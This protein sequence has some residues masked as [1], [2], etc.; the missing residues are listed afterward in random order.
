MPVSGPT[1]H[2]Q[3]M[4]AYQE[5]QHELEA[6]R[7]H[8]AAAGVELNEL[9]NNR[10]EAMVDLAQHYLPELTQEAV[11]KTWGDVQQ[12]VWGVLMRKE[13]H[14]QRLTAAIADLS[15]KRD[16]AEQRLQSATL[17]LDAAT[18]AQ[19]EISN[20][21]SQELSA[22]KRFAEL[23]DRAAQAEAALQRAEANLAEIEIDANR[24]LPSYENSALF[25][26]LHKRGFLTPQ[27]EH[28]GITRS[29]DQW[30]GRYIGYREA[31]H[32]YEFLK[33]TPAHMKDVIAEDRAAL[34]T[35]LDELEKQRDIVAERHGLPQAIQ[36]TG[37]LTQQREEILIELDE[38]ETE[39]ERVQHELTEI[40]NT[41]GPYYHEAIKKF[42]DMI[43][44][45][46]PAALADRARETP[47]INDDR[48]VARLQGLVEA[49][50]EMG[51]QV[52]ERHAR[53]EQLM[54]H[55]QSVGTLISRFRAAGF[56]SSQ[57]QFGDAESVV[58]QLRA[59]RDGSG[60][61]EDVWQR[62]RRSHRWGPSAADQFV[63]VATHPMTQ[64][65][66]SAMAHA[67]AGALVAKATQAGGRRASSQP[68]WSG[69]R[70]PGGGRRGGG[71]H[72]RDSF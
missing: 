69:G 52:R 31:R 29:M 46:D 23:S 62:L 20:V 42:R 17:A 68:K 60:S 56:D 4:L 65:L 8:V 26:Y 19:G 33:T 35:V 45:A 10:G 24:K 11:R 38:I 51:D 43:A 3:L 36:K 63:R 28:R 40:E 54:S 64:V 15:S 41:R 53:I 5:A 7:G 1:I 66:I 61:Y 48:I 39:T 49:M 37:D 6:A 18:E 12:A 70:S 57:A 72:T 47:E 21:V 22:D 27:Y 25:M 32:G 59:V 58:E 9:S 71:F 30:L 34:N 14:A 2:Q 44:D 55:L 13:E 16:A 50:D 67:A